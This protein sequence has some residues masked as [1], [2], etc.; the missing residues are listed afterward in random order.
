M[1]NESKASYIQIM[2]FSD[3]A[4][5]VINEAIHFSDS[6]HC[7]NVNIVHMFL[8][9]V[10]NTKLGEAILE[11]LD[12]S[13]DMIYSSYQTLASFGAYGY[14]VSDDV[15]FTPD[16]F[17]N[18]VA[19]VIGTLT[20]QAIM[21]RRS[22]SCSELFDAVL[23]PEF[24]QL[25]KFLDYIGT[26]I[27]TLRDLKSTEF[28]IPED[29]VNFVEDLNVSENIINS[30]YSGVDGYTDEIIEILSRKKKS[31]P[32]L[33]GEAGVGKTSIVEAFTQRIIK[34]D[35]PESFK[36]THVCYINSSLLTAGTRFRGDFEERMKSLLSWAADTNVILFLD[37]VHTFINLGGRGGESAGNMI[38]KYLSDGAIRIIGATTT[39]EYHEFIE[40]DSAF[41]RRLQRLD[42]KE[43]SADDA[44][45]MIKNSIKDYEAYHNVRVS[46]DTIELAV[47]LSDRY[48]KDKF[49]PD[50]AYT[51][52]DQA[53]ARVKLAGSKNVTADNILDVVSKTTG[54][55]VSRLSNTEQKQLLSLEDTIGKNLI[56]QKEA[57]KTVC[58]AIRRAKADIHETSKP[59]ASFLFVGPTGVGKTELCKVLSKEVAIGDT[60]LIKIDMSE[61]NDKYSTSKL[62]GSAPGFVGYGE[63]GQLT[64]KVKHN[65]HSIILFDEIEKADP[66][67]FNIF[68]QLLDEGRLTDGSGTT[69]DFTN[70]IIVMTSNAGYGADM[71][72]TKSL[73]FST[74]TT[75]NKK[76]PKEMEKIAIKALEET[77]RPELIN[78][79]D[80]IV[81]FEK[82]SK[83]ENKEVAKLL[84]DKLSKRLAEKSIE[85]TF[86][87]SVIDHVVENG[88][89][90]KYGARNLRREIQDTVE[91]VIADAVLDGTLSS[92]SK[93]VATYA[94]NTV[95]LNVKK[96]K[97]VV[98]STP[99]KKTKKE[100]VIPVR[101]KIVNSLDSLKEK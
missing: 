41:D 59:L 69:V 91:D 74:G 79:L 44:I 92:G 19:Y 71:M 85:I 17:S 11:H 72:N 31:N 13:F 47:R 36:D 96:S 34:G 66:E 86:D 43:P 81:I 65:P 20:H 39:K 38:K 77:F 18:D 100:V 101:G 28:I 40:G 95:K 99:S 97:K 87:Q 4:N 78:R 9:L 57:V 49:L 82:L 73:G 24:E 98:T 37:E 48:I 56:G 33:V 25:V 5:K 55:N 27:D 22:V 90:D 94:D 58:K 45:Q 21:A 83:D 76:S 68:L 63:G 60:P 2:G 7:E 52:L 10:N 46:K 3:E 53:C 51:I 32:C 26:D 8:S 35:V 61:Y 30:T 88:Y 89:S 29:I 84:L 6:E 1:A 80:N 42:I 16:Y 64:E 23:D 50:K 62:I 75:E 15:A 70:C 54:I 67:V 12:C 93:A 14:F